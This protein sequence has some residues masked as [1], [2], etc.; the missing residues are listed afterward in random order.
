MED[1]L[2]HLESRVDEL[3]EKLGGLEHRL[4]VLETG[5]GSAAAAAVSVQQETV[6]PMIETVRK[7]GKTVV[8][9]ADPMHGNTETTADGIKTRRFSNILRELEQAFEKNQYVVGA[10]RKELA[11]SLNLS[12]TQVKKNK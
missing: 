3:V 10:E 12:E 9:C 7:T 1:R 4:S 11:K 8:W 6:P 2:Q 5:D